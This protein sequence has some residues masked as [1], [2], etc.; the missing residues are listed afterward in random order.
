MSSVLP[1]KAAWL[2]DRVEKFLPE[3]NTVVTQT[4]ERVEYKHLVIAMGL[5]LRYDLVKGL[6]EA[7]KEDPQVCLCLLG[8]EF[9]MLHLTWLSFN[10]ILMLY[11]ITYFSFDLKF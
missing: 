5:E 4:G 11:F 6:A 2:Q 1:S 3:E 7:L 9:Y 8:N 10:V